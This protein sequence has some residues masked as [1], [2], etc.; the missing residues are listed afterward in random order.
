MSQRLNIKKTKKKIAPKINLKPEI[1]KINGYTLLLLPNNNS[2]ITVT[3][4]MNNGYINETRKNTGINHLLEHIIFNAWKKCG[5]KPCMELFRY[6]GISGN[7]STN[8]TTISYYAEGLKDHTNYIIDYITSITTKPY[9]YNE[10]IKSE[11]NPVMNELLIIDNN[12]VNKLYDKLYKNLFIQEGLQ[13][14]NDSGQQ[15]RNLKHL[16]MANMKKVISE[17]Y[18]PSNIIYTVSGDYNKREILRNFRSKLPKNNSEIRT[19]SYINCFNEKC[20]RKIID[21]DPKATIATILYVF[22]VKMY[23][24]VAGQYE[25]NI[26]LNCLQYLIGNYLRYVKKYTYGFNI[27]KTVNKCG[28]VIAFKTNSNKKNIDDIYATFDKLIGKYQKE[29]INSKL[30]N[31]EKRR[32]LFNFLNS[33]NSPDQL[34]EFYSKQYIHQCDQGRR[35]YSPKEIKDII[36]NIDLEKVRNSLRNV[37]GEFRIKAYQC[38]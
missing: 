29:L 28:T 5:H 8:T 9:L 15:I 14:F 27:S 3:S 17:Y 30:L 18:V 13:Y 6:K 24:G 34:A 37:F 25:L 12:R 11:K 26:A 4:Y 31:S 20:S 19:H 7:A 35:L 38:Y 2:T 32:Y 16:T 1:V 23:A 33:Y 10:L 36:M 21:I 22:P